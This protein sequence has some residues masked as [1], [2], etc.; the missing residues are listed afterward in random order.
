MRKAIVAATAALFSLPA[1]T[2]QLSQGQASIPNF[3]GM[4]AHPSI[5]GFEPPASGPGPLVNK[6]RTPDGPQKGA[7]LA[8][9]ASA[10]PVYLI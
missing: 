4:W 3:S 8:T 7:D 2:Q 1:F 5:P 10:H 9:T 6:S